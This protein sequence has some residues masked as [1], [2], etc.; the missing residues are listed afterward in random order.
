MILLYHKIYLESPTVFWI[1]VDNFYRQMCEIEHK[2]VVYLSEYD[3]KDE[4]QIVITFDGIY[5]NVLEYAAPILNKFGYPFELFIVGNY[6]GEDNSFDTPEPKAFFASEDELKELI[7]YGGRLEWHSRSHPDFGN[8]YDEKIIEKELE[9]KKSIKLLDPKGFKFFAYPHGKFN[10][11]V[12]NIVKKNFIG[13][14]ADT[15]GDDRDKYRLTRKIVTKE[16]TFKKYKI[17]VII[18]SYK[19]GCFLPEA[20]ESV[21]RQTRPVDEIIIADDASPDNTGEIAEIY[22]DK[23][24]SLIRYV[25]NESN[26]GIVRNFN[27]AIRLAKGDYVCFLG[28]DNRFRSDYIEKTARVL[29]KNNDVAIAYTDFALFGVRAKMEYEKFNK[30][31]Q[32]GIKSNYYYII[33]FP[34]FN[35]DTLQLLDRG[36]NFIHGSSMYRKKVAEMVGGYKARENFPEDYNLFYRM[37]KSGWKAKRAPYPLLEY[38][39][40]SFDQA[41]IVLQS[42]M[43][44]KFYKEQAKLLKEEKTKL[45][46]SILRLINVGENLLKQGDNKNAFEIFKIVCEINPKIRINIETQ[47]KPDLNYIPEHI[48][49][50]LQEIEKIIDNNELNRAETELQNIIKN[51]PN[52]GAAYNELGGIYYRKGEKEKALNYIR[53]A[54]ENDPSDIFIL[55]NLANLY[56]ELGHID[57]ALSIFEKV[58]TL[59]PNDVETLVSIGRIS[60]LRGRIDDAR[61]FYETALNYDPTNKDVIVLIEGLHQDILKEDTNLSK[62]MK[63]DW[64]KW[65]KESAR[66]YVH[67]TEK[68]ENEEEFDQSGKDNVDNIIMPK[69]NLITDGKDP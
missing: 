48:E 37:I 29:D 51:Y 12:L 61:V 8:I 54:S 21:L 25:K 36:I 6:I 9:I 45:Q 32:G 47:K 58:I 10:D 7:R 1:D 31:W 64:D 11:K 40:H 5:K 63:E 56:L 55:K 69:L 39:Q 30:Q 59:N 46:N 15:D 50:K 38:R 42:Y 26:L 14:V 43:E 34:E 67:T 16:S 44:L 23:F 17:S 60:E 53:K 33:N 62:R 65:A 2:K 19:Y 52:F 49:K 24:P 57:E 35:E 28:A 41:N 66:Y 27:N 4:D 68:E 20:I 22:Q 18:P 3:P 13:A